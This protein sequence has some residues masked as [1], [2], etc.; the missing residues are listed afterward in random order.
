[1]CLY[2]TGTYP[3]YWVSPL[4]W[5]GKTRTNGHSLRFDHKLS[6]GLF[7]SNASLFCIWQ[8]YFPNCFFKFSAENR[9]RKKIRHYDGYRLFATK[10]GAEFGKTQSPPK[11]PCQGRGQPKRR[12]IWELASK[13]RL[14]RS[15]QLAP[16]KNERRLDLHSRKNSRG[17][18]IHI[19]PLFF[20]VFR[21]S[22]FLM[23]RQRSQLFFSRESSEGKN[24][25]WRQNPAA[26]ASAVA[27]WS[28]FW[29]SGCANNRRGETLKTPPPK[30]HPKREEDTKLSSPFSPP[31]SLPRRK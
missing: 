13:R 18:A 11:T 9:V 28:S 3:T 22:L 17:A 15:H 19:S 14:R 12:E 25:L 8:P 7:S 27:V 29:E 5:E 23:D 20:I 4:L 16:Q 2:F 1:M 10:M 6:I 24:L 30:S 21:N 26:A 31:A